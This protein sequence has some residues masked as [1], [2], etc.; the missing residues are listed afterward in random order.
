MK[1]ESTRTIIE[2]VNDYTCEI[3]ANNN[4]ILVK[5]WRSKTGE[6]ASKNLG[7]YSSLERALTR[8]VDELAIDSIRGRTVALN[9]AVEAIRESKRQMAKLLMEILETGTKVSRR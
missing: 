7:Y 2:L 4:Y 9:E 1:Q 3:D 8:L 5:N 6:K